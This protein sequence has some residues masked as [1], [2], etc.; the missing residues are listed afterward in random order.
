MR[1]KSISYSLLLLVLLAVGGCGA[2]VEPDGVAG[3]SSEPVWRIVLMDPLTS[4]IITS[5]GRYVWR[6]YSHPTEERG[7]W[8]VAHGCIVLRPP[9][10]YVGDPLLYVGDALLY[11]EPRANG[12]WYESTAPPGS[13]DC[14]AELF[15]LYGGGGLDVIAAHEKKKKR[16]Q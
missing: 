5:D 1:I 7:T 16:K 8:T 11:L 6:S 15:Y 12:E 14:K 4:L 13:P 9:D 3:P 2:D 10:A